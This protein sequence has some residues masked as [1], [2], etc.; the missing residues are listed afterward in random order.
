[1]PNETI[2]YELPYNLGIQFNKLAEK[3]GF[4]NHNT[5][6]SE[7]VR[8][9]VKR[10]EEVRSEV[11]KGID[12]MEA[13]RYTKIS[14]REESDQLVQKVQEEGRKILAKN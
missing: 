10:V 7:L 2:N 8:A 5:F 1:M 9:Y 11:Q 12:D 3:T 6:L 14:T 13:G 4:T